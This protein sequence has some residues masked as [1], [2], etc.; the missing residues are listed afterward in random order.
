[1][2][3]LVIGV[4]VSLSW[5][6]AAREDPEMEF[7]DQILSEELPE[8]EDPAVTL[9]KSA[10]RDFGEFDH[11][12]DG[13]ID[14]LEITARFGAAVNPIDRFYFFS[15]ATYMASRWQWRYTICRWSS[16]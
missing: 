9:E 8:A 13:Q 5:L 10:K 14:A 12:K 6:A 1:M 2:I 7:L 15:H 4:V 16:S 11:N 3:R